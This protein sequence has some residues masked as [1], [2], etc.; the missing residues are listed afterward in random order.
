MTRYSYGRFL[1]SACVLL[2]ASQAA[3]AF[4][5]FSFGFGANDYDHPRR[6]PPIAPPARH[7]PHPSA[8]LMHGRQPSPAPDLRYAGYFYPAYPASAM[9]PAPAYS[10]IEEAQPQHTK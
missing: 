8:Y 5:C 7:A 9:M 3:Q 2:G 10:P 1:A 6:L 4:F